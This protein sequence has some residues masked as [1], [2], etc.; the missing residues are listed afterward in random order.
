MRALHHRDEIIRAV[1][2]GDIRRLDQLA[3]QLATA[4]ENRRLLQALGHC[5]EC[6]AR[7]ALHSPEMT[8]PATSQ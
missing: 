7:A 3:A 2:G 1:K 6:T 8:R 5:P 4:E